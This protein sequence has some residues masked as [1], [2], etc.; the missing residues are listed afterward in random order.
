M[1]S[2]TPNGSGI[3]RD[4]NSIG[5]LNWSGLSSESGENQDPIEANALKVVRYYLLCLFNVWF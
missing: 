2:E 3:T 4:S 5:S 1:S